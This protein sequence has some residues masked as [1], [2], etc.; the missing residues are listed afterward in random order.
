MHKRF[1]SYLTTAVLVA[2]GTNLL[3]KDDSK[4]NWHTTVGAGVGV[5]PIYEGSE[6][7][8]LL[9][10]PY[11]T[12]MYKDKVSFGAEGLKVRLLKEHPY[13]VGI[14]LTYD[15]GRDEN[16]NALFGNNNDGALDGLD[17]IDSALGARAYGNYQFDSFA[18]KGGITQYMGSDN[19]GLILDVALVKHV[20][21][22]EKLSLTFLVGTEWADSKYMDTFFGISIDESM[23]SKF[24]KFDAKAGFKHV[25]AAVNS[26][27]TINKSWF[28]MLSAQVK[29]LQGDAAKSPIS[30]SD[31]GVFVFSAIGYK[32]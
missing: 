28:V 19:N 3:A 1:I 8:T 11:F 5:F 4:S 20:A 30:E 13:E 14:G 23:R 9:P 32:L 25:S 7:Y 18:V 21:L 22:D 24:T 12:I 16:G 15:P 31:T 2:S 29:Q 27:Y 17:K 6:K 10:I 26:L